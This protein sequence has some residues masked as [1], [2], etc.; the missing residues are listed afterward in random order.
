MANVEVLTYGFSF[1]S[2]QGLFGL[3][4]NALLTV[5]NQTIVVDTGVT[6]D[7]DT[8]RRPTLRFTS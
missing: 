7:F 6:I 4:T 3:A 5:G 1:G 8:H 2:D